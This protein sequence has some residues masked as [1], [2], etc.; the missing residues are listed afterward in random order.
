MD[1]NSCEPRPSL[2]N[3]RE[4]LPD[5]SGIIQVIPQYKA[6]SRCGGSCD[7]YSHGCVATATRTKLIDVM[8]VRA[9]YDHDHMTE[10]ECGVIEVEEDTSCSCDCPVQ[11]EDCS[12]HHYYDESGCR[13]L[14]KDQSGRNRCI[15]RGM[16]WDP[17]KCMCTC[18][19]SVW[20]VCSTGYVYDLSDTC[21][22]V[23][24]V[25]MSNVT[26]L[27]ML[28]AF[29][30]GGALTIFSLVLY[31]RRQIRYFQHRLLKAA[32][33]ESLSLATE[34]A[35]NISLTSECMIQQSAPNNFRRRSLSY[36]H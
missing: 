28:A 32:D 31:Y 34:S 10:T 16:Q 4:H 33:S 13:C 18:P 17:L 3:L 30:I 1:S 22:C 14:C 29:V 12:A 36:T 26:G 15:S 9:R 7:L 25:A 20:R 19:T 5:V 6:V 2:V 23:P 8:V 27:A 11:A 24:V 21:R 35:S